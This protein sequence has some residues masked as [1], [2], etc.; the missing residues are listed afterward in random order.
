M[1]HELIWWLTL[2]CRW[3][4]CSGKGPCWCCTHSIYFHRTKKRTWQWYRSN[5]L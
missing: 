4:W 2:M 3:R 5:Y 1:K